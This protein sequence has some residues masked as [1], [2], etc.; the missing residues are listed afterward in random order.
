MQG[1]YT[2]LIKYVDSLSASRNKLKNWKRKIKLNNFAIF[3]ELSSVFVTNNDDKTLTVSLNT[4]IVQHLTA[5]QNEFEGYFA[6]LNGN[7]LDLVR[8]PFRLLVEK[9]PDE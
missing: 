4:E 1:K 9:V 8:N 3:E 5:L 2:N 6:E 7:V